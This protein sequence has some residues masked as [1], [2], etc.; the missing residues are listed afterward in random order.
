MTIPVWEEYLGPLLLCHESRGPFLHEDT[1]SS[2]PSDDL[3]LS[4][5]DSDEERREGFM[6]RPGSSRCSF[7]P[8]FISQNLVSWF[9]LALWGWEEKLSF[10]LRKRRTGDWGT[11]AISATIQEL[12]HT[13]GEA[14]ES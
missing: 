2:R 13:H 10:V 8:S 5:K 9:H 3:S 1:P 4:P 14:E 12:P 7:C 6:A 11:L